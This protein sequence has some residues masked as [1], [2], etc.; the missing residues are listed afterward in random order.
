MAKDTEAKIERVHEIVRVARRTPSDPERPIRRV[1]D[2][3]DDRTGL[4]R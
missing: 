2:L 1:D 4:P 3:F